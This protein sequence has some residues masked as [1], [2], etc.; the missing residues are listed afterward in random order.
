LSRKS[1]GGLNAASGPREGTIPPRNRRAENVRLRGPVLEPESGG[2]LET[3]GLG[4]PSH[5]P[6]SV[7][8]S[9]HQ[10]TIEVPHRDFSN[11]GGDRFAGERT[12]CSRGHGCSRI[13]EFVAPF[14]GSRAG[15]AAATGSRLVCRELPGADPATTLRLAHSNG[16]G[17]PPAL[18]FH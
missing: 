11:R 2:C 17:K 15:V 6:A 5:R 4:S 3:V 18:R 13:V 14:P 8:R 1:N 12:H 16:R 7:P 9:A 10:Y